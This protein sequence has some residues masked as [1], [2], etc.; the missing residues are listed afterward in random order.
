MRK[1][2]TLMGL[3]A[4]LAIAATPVAAVPITFTGSGTAAGI[5]VSASATFDFSGNILTIT[6]QNTSGSHAAQDAPGSTLTGIFFDLAGAPTLTPVSA[7]LPAGSSIIQTATCSPAG[8]CATTNVGGEWGFQYS[9]A[10]LPA[11]GPDYGI[12]SAGY[13]STGLAGN[14]GNFNNGAA[15]TDLDNVASLDGIGF[16]IVSGAAGFD[17]NGGLAAVPLI[18]DS[19]QFVLNGVAGLDT[20]D[21]SNVLFRYGTAYTEDSVPG[22]GDG[23]GGGGGGGSVPEPGTLALLA[24]G[25][26]G[27]HFAL[28]RRKNLRPRLPR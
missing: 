8:A 18:E 15:G 20:D 2:L 21:I 10:G 17:P 7:T 3:G 26:L 5:A 1:P 12:A 11:G 13:L 14:I 6:L 9:A 28:L 24:I 16:G 27:L 19:V 23:G 4:S 22:G 25:L